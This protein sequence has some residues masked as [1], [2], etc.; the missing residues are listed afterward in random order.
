V[1]Q[2]DRQIKSASLLILLVVCDQTSR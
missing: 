2:Q 1:T